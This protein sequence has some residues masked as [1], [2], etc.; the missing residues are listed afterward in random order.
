[1]KTITVNALL[2]GLAL[3]LGACASDDSAPPTPASQ[4]T[5]DAAAK[6]HAEQMAAEE[7]KANAAREMA[8][9]QQATRDAQAQQAAEQ[10]AAAQAAAAKA[11]SEKAAAEKAAA[12]KAAAEAA[13]TKA[14]ADKA[15]AESAAREKAAADKAALEKAAAEKAAAASAA[16]AAAATT[17]PAKTPAKTT[18]PPVTTPAAGDSN[19]VAEMETTAGKMVIGFLP[20]VAPNHV[21][22]FVDLSQKGFYD[23]TLFHRVLKGFMIQGGDPNTKDPSKSAMWGSGGPGYKVN[24]EFNATKHVRGTLSMARSS[25]PNSAGSQFFICHGT[26]DFLDGQYT[27]FGE[28]LSGYDVLDKIATAPTTMAGNEKSRP[29]EP[30]KITKITI[31]PRTPA[32]VKQGG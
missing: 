25:D 28:L 11:A 31:R 17:T 6:A 3:A 12:E 32:D 23:G 5:Q 9:A 24:A 4:P 22:N 1:M 29:V 27:A 26:A 21:K 7:A 20:A 19:V 13:A 14:A 10:K 30:V 2:L 15:A 18:E 16:G 8:M